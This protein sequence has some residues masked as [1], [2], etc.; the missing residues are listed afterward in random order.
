MRQLESLFD[1]GSIAGLTDRQVLERFTAD[2]RS[3]SG[4]AAFAALVSRHGPIVLAVCRQ[5]LDDQHLAEDAFQAVFFVLARRAG[6]IRDPGVLSAWLHGIAVRTAGTAGR[7]I[8]RA[9]AERRK[10]RRAGGPIVS[11][12]VSR[13]GSRVA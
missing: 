6:T 10:L 13:S 7:A 5:L 8:V 11:V 2:P 4:E 3:A 9:D 12:A 1:G